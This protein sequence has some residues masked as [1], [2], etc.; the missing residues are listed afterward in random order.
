MRF[1]H[2]RHRFH[3]LKISAKPPSSL[4]YLNFLA[5]EWLISVLSLNRHRLEQMRELYSN[6]DSPPSPDSSSPPGDPFYD[7]F[8][9]FRLIGRAYVYLSNLFY[10]VPLTHK[11]PI[12]NVSFL[13]LLLLI[14]YLIKVWV[15]NRLKP[16]LCLFSDSLF[17]AASRGRERLLANICGIKLQ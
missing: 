6:E 13:S 15:L 5:I 3:S 9:W 7:R 4:L 10:P 16:A 11:V 14:T 12:V 17:F 8:P 2:W 1:T